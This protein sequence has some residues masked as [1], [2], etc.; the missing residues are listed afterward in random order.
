MRGVGTSSLQRWPDRTG[1]SRVYWDG[2]GQEQGGRET[3]VELAAFYRLVA[4]VMSHP[5]AVRLDEDS[6]FKP[7]L[8]LDPELGITG[9]DLVTFMSES[10]ARR[11]ADDSFCTGIERL[12][13]EVGITD[14]TLVT[15]MSDSV[16]VRP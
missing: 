7:L 15:V 13:P 3:T 9:K 14:K 16:A 6:L 5:V 8:R 12:E 10:V 2:G 1:G 11:L 4:T